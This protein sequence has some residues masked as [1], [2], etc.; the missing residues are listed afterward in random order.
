MSLTI[1]ITNSKLNKKVE[2]FDSLSEYVIKPHIISEVVRSELT[3]LRTSNAHSKIR[4]EVRGGGKKPWRQKGTGRA[5]HGSIRSPIWVGGGVTFGPRNTTN[6]HL[7]INKSTRL[8]ALKSILKDRLIEDAVYMFEESFDYPKTKDALTL[9]SKITS[10]KSLKNKSL[11]IV[12]TTK[13]KDSVRGFA[14]SEVKLINAG[15][16]KL[17]K[18]VSSKAFVLTPNAR[19]VLESRL[20]R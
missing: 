6:W 11:A 19:E 2:A 8:S 10:A 14:N 13:D 20:S 3:N 16:I 4:S 18:L 12:Y 17:H 5:R 7:K 15:N 1:T 9:V